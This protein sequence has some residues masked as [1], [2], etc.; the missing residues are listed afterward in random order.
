MLPAS[1]ELSND[2]VAVFLD[3]FSTHC[4]EDCQ[5]RSMG[6]C[7]SKDTGEPQRRQQ[8][9]AVAVR[10]HVDLDATQVF[11]DAELLPQQPGTEGR[12]EET[13]SSICDGV[14]GPVEVA[15]CEQECSIPAAA[16]IAE[17]DSRNDSEA[18][19]RHDSDVSWGCDASFTADSGSVGASHVSG[20]GESLFSTT[21]DSRAVSFDVGTARS[22]DFSSVELP[23]FNPLDLEPDTDY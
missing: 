10:I 5:S 15:V 1:A 16:D 20:R 22:Y 12:E 7:T 6:C 19:F 14:S 17:A 23:A 4:C 11:L 2:T 3:S 13:V 21:I 8:K 9:N 18:V